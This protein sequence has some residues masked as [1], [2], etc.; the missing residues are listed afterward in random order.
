MTVIKYRLLAN[1]AFGFEKKKKKNRRRERSDWTL[2]C[3]TQTVKGHFFNESETESRIIERHWRKNSGF[4]VI[5][6]NEFLFKIEIFLSEIRVKIT[7]KELKNSN[8]NC[9]Y[10]AIKKWKVKFSTIRFINYGH[11]IEKIC[12]HKNYMGYFAKMFHFC[13]LGNHFKFQLTG[14]FWMTF[15]IFLVKDNWS[16]LKFLFRRNYPYIK[17][18]ISIFFKECSFYKN[19]SS[20]IEDSL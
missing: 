19:H 18:N 5:W 10:F 4:E 16:S 8:K 9:V 11:W 1:E 20:Y 15:T 12:L 6:L 14:C 2:T 3:T 17:I 7:R 13:A